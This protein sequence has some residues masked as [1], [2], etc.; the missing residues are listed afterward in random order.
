MGM[1][2]IWTFLGG[3]ALF[4]FAMSVLEEGLKL[5]AGRSFKKFLQKQTEKKFRAMAGGTIVTALLQ[6]SSVVML[7]TLSF[8]GAGIIGMRNALA[9]TLG[10]NLGTT[11]DS[12]IVA[13]LGFKVNIAL[14]AYPLLALTIIGMFFLRNRR[15]NALVRF[16]TGFALLFIALDLMKQSASVLI[17]EFDLARYAGFSP[18]LYI[19]I[20]ILITFL[21]QSSAATMAI[22]LTALHNG[23][24]PFESAAAI[25]IGSELGTTL[26]L[27]IASSG[28]NIDKKRVAM[29]NFLFNATILLL[30][31][32]LL[33]PLSLFILK[34]VRI[35]DYLIA[36]V[37][38]QSFINL[39]GILLFYPLLGPFARLLE[40][41]FRNREAT[42]GLQYIRP[43]LANTLDEPLIPAE[44]EILRLW[45][46]ALLHN[47][48]VMAA[49]DTPVASEEIR[50]VMRNPEEAYQRLKLLQGQILEYLAA[51]P[52]HEM[53]PEMLQRSGILIT[54]LR[55]VVH[56]AKNVKDIHHNLQDL[57]GSPND[58]L[59]GLFRLALA[60]EAQFYNQLENLARLQ[61]SDRIPQL[62][63]LLE[64]N[65][66]QH[67]ARIEKTL[68]LLKENKIAELDASTMLN[69][70][71]EIYSCNK[72]LAEVLQDLHITV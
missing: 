72:A 31:S 58:H 6:S 26:K 55:N 24:L 42:N 48:G 21:I 25:V 62:H 70:Y 45:H 35:R 2:E 33:Y 4:I 36:L 32:A 40:K 38:F 18:Y 13:T 50:S 11:L 69:V 44:K 66:G 64:V 59:H 63:R 65:R 52:R 71:R 27:L 8:V 14:L 46:M 37:F 17:Q 30:A 53:E 51:L 56:A 15:I 1:M 41:L 12:W 39:V 19:P 67:N 23:L 3:T 61:E 34:V 28:G 43:A 54:A 7:M 68:V 5:L 10:S 22:T 9:I 29:G 57:E 16:L 60:D 20:G 49:H 47:R